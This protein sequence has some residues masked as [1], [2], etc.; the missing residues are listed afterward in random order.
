[1]AHIYTE[2][3]FN[4]LIISKYKIYITEAVIDMSIYNNSRSN[5]NTF[6]LFRDPEL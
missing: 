6:G 4:I 5:N 1:M 3:T 2:Y